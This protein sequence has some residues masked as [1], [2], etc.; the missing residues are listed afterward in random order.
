[1]D[2]RGWLNLIGR[3]VLPTLAV[4]VLLIASLKLAEQ[5]AGGSGAFVDAYRWVLGAAV[6]ALL[7]LFVLIGRRL[8]SLRRDLGREAPGARLS[9]RLLLTLVLLAVPPVVVV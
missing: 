5:A 6:L 4:L 1:M 7:V 9:R 8:W 2:R 3:R